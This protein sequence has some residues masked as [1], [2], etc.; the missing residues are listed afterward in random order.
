MLKQKNF[1][2]SLWDEVVSTV[3]YFLNICHTKLKIKVP[4]EVWSGKR[5]SVSHLKVFGSIFYKHVSDGRRRNPDDNSEPMILVRYHKNGVYRL[6]N[7]INQKIMMTR[8]IVIDENSTGG[9]NSGDPIQ[10]PLI[11]YDFD[12]ANN[13]VKVEDIIDIPVKVEETI[14]LLDTV[15][16]EDGVASN[17]QRPKITR[18]HPIRL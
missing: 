13:D 10:K 3:V 14:D 1:P 11:I 4:E 7:P 18:A 12:E 6:F 5:P 9:W 8:D 15:E 2:K 17:N 16:I